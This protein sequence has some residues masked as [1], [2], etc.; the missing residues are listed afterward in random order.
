MLAAATAACGAARPPSVCTPGR[1][2][3]LAP[4]PPPPPPACG[5]LGTLLGKRLIARLGLLRAGGTA[6]AIHAVLLGL[7]TALFASYLSA[8]PELGPAGGLALAGVAAAGAAGW[9]R[10]G[11]VPLP[12]VAFAGGGAGQACGAEAGVWGQEELCAGFLHAEAGERFACTGV[13]W[14]RQRCL[15]W[16]LLWSP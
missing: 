1:P 4:P 9:P 16:P 13:A 8:P 5:F 12:V 14:H 15:Q 3:T 11:G 6:L 10:L 2:P 7:A